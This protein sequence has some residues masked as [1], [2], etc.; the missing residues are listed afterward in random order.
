MPLVMRLLEP[1]LS[2][3]RTLTELA[4]ELHLTPGYMLRLFKS[5]TGMPPMAYLSRRRVETA[6][7]LL[8][9]TSQ[10]V[11]Q[12]GRSVGWSSGRST[13]ASTAVST[14]RHRRSRRSPPGCA[15][16]ST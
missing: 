15:M 8:L 16:R 4:G 9:H 6:V 12:I 10:P 3:P 2:H 5:S 1:R 11:T 14:T 7:G 13:G